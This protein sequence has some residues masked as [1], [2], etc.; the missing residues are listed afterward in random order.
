MRT[1]RSFLHTSLVGTEGAAFLPRTIFAADAA[2]A[3]GQAPAEIWRRFISDAE[4]V[5]AH[6]DCA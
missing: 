4:R 2:T 6:Y 1:R 3:A 5:I